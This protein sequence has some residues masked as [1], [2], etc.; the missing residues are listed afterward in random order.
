MVGGRRAAR[1]KVV[2]RKAGASERCR[3][4]A[5]ALLTVRGAGRPMS[6]ENVELSRHRAAA[7]LDKKAG[8]AAVRPP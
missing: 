8:A 6:D 2:G 4:D 5:A 7:R 1:A 3:A